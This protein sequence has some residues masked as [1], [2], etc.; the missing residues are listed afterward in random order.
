MFKIITIGFFVLCACDIISTQQTSN[1]MV[2]GTT[3]G[4]AFIQIGQYTITKS[5]EM[6]N[7]LTEIESIRKIRIIFKHLD[8]IFCSNSNENIKTCKVLTILLTD[9]DELYLQGETLKKCLNETKIEKSR[10]FSNLIS[11]NAYPAHAEENFVGFLDKIYEELDEKIVK[12]YSNAQN[13]NT[14]YVQCIETTSKT[15]KNVWIKL[16]DRFTFYAE[17]LNSLSIN[18]LLFTK[19][20]NIQL[21]I[22]SD[23]SHLVVWPD[24]VGTYKYYDEN[25][26][27]LNGV[28]VYPITTKNAIYTLRQQGSKVIGTKGETFYFELENLLKNCLFV[29]RSYFIC[30]VAEFNLIPTDLATSIEILSDNGGNG[31]NF[32]TTSPYRSSGASSKNWS[33]IS[34]V[35]L[36]L[37]KVLLS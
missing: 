34:V 30:Q 21:P 28:T 10:K 22:L 26:N 4:K 12:P 27:T 14:T 2:S 11:I 36:V 35:L 1:K 5:F 23:I 33:W 18:T 37:L 32:L 9:Y 19:D 17:A 16:R 24:I 8:G 6:D 13:I 29:Q 3:M 15:M 31:V 7:I 20:D 25:S